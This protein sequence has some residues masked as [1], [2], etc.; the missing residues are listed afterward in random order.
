MR[1]ERNAAGA[2]SCQVACLGAL[3]R[4]ARL[5]LACLDLSS[6]QVTWSLG[7]L[8]DPRLFA[9]DALGRIALIPWWRLRELWGESAPLSAPP[10]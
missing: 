10:V 8:S 5:R 7:S 9:P 1:G 2:A 6:L 3:A 4:C